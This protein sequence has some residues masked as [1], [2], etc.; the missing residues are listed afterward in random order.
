[1]IYIYHNKTNGQLLA[2]SSLKAISVNTGI[3]YDTLIYNFSRQSK[4]FYERDDFKIVKTELIKSKR[5]G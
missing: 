1:M 4:E 3:G 2:F 5:N